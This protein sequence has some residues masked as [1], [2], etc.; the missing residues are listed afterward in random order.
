MVNLH[1]KYE[2]Q[3]VQQN[4]S[5]HDPFTLKR[6]EQFFSFFHKGAVKILDVG[7]NTGRG[8][9]RFKELNPNLTL[10]GLDCVQER[11]D[12]LPECYSQKV[13]GL[14]TDI[15]MEDRFF[16]V[17]TAGEF[18]EHLY[19]ADVDKTLCEFQR[20][21]KIGGR[22]LLTTPNPNYI[23]NKII[24]MSV[25]GVSHLT[26]HFPEVLRLRLQMH[27]F[28]GVKLYG[29]GRVSQY[30]GWHFPLMSIYGSYLVV[31]NKY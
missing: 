30:L 19:P 17:I 4:R 5:E 27:G 10:F 31:A 11:L 14:S 22:L 24:G 25:Y 1:K 8:G 26:Q 13:Y 2:V 16:D 21:L 12:V 29:S 3:N 9:L 23:K 7:C 6:Y 20:V 15:P 28:S 18:L